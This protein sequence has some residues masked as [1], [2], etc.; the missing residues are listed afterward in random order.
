MASVTPPSELIPPGDSLYEMIDG[1][2][3][4]PPPMGSYENDIANLLAEMI[5]EH[6][7]PGRIGRAFVELLFWID[8]LRN[9]KRRPDVAFVSAA[10][11]P[12]GRRAPRGEAWDLIPDLAVEVVSESNS[13]KEVLRKVVDYL[14]AGVQQVWI[15]YPD[16]KQIHVYSNLTS[17][18]IYT[19]SDELDGSEVVH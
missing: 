4:E 8:K 1:Q 3:V 14:R 12:V 16:L 10:R 18:L 9:L 7:R 11:W 19:E 13:A 2:I 6:A 5:N 17:S 15:I